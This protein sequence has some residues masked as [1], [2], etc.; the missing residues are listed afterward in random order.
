M[1]ISVVGLVVSEPRWSHRGASGVCGGRG[2]N[3]LWGWWREDGCVLE[4][5]DVAD[6][7][8]RAWPTFGLENS[9]LITSSRSADCYVSKKSFKKCN[10]MVQKPIYYFT[11]FSMPLR[12]H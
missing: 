1:H 3:S 6:G 8:G 5:E 11:V 9:L 7:G 4:V 10:K 12:G 2:L